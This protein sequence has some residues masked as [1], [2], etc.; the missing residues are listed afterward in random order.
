MTQVSTDLSSVITDE[1]ITILPVGVL[2]SKLVAQAGTVQNLVKIQ[3]SGMSPTLA[4]WKTLLI[5]AGAFHRHWPGVRP[6]LK[7]GGMSGY[8]KCDGL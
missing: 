5:Y 3:W 7:E 6:D 1:T 8:P 4:T 2:E